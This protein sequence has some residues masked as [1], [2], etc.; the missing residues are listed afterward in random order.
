M[1]DI[2]SSDE[3]EQDKEEENSI[4]VIPDFQNRFYI[5]VPKLEEKKKHDFE[6]LPGHFTAQKIVSNFR[7]DRYLVKLMS[8]EKQL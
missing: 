7:R 2:E 6:H 5:D 4:E 8:G 1:R 3:E